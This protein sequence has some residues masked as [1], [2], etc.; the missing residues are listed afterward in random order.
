MGIFFLKF[1]FFILIYFLLLY[2]ANLG[3][4]RWIGVERRQVW[5][6]DNINKHHEKADTVH[7]RILIV[8][9]FS[10]PVIDFF[11][12]YNYWYQNP[13]TYILVVLLSGQLLKAYMEW[14]YIED[15]RVYTYT[16]LI[17]GIN[18]TLLVLLMISGYLYLS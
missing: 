17:T 4:S 6:S 3:I 7:R 18:A 10:C 16:L 12:D 2:S 14:K 15:K 9:L 11:Y 5:S 8:V 13:Y 1:T